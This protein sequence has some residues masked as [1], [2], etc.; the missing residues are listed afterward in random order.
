MMAES[1][2]PN[3]Y[4]YAR[5]I[6]GFNHGEV[7]GVRPRMLTENE[8]L[9]PLP[10]TLNSMLKKTT[11]TGDIGMF[12]IRP[13]RYPAKSASAR[14]A[15]QQRL[16]SLPH[17]DPRH[18]QIQSFNRQQYGSSGYDDR[19]FLPSYSRDTSSDIGCVCV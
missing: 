5:D 8:R 11:E 2:V 1:R 12:S 3:S 18:M 19:R 7:Y 10:S 6:S 13:S 4:D 17:F 15:A 9:V 16:N 14:N